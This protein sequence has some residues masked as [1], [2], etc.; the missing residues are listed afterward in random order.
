MKER[1][2][3]NYMVDIRDLVTEHYDQP[4][5]AR[6][7]SGGWDVTANH[8]VSV[9]F[10]PH[11]PTTPWPPP[12]DIDLDHAA[13]ADDAARVIVATH[14]L[15][16]APTD[17][18]ERLEELVGTAN[19]VIDRQSIFWVSRSRYAALDSELRSLHGRPSP[20]PFSGLRLE[21]LPPG[22]LRQFLKFELRRAAALDESHRRLLCLPPAAS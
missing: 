2:D 8:C 10:I 3:S 6:W 14:T 22:E 4:E 11:L 5:L 21:D 15:I 18:Q 7:L 13:D 20:A 16:V 19:D 9:A 17:G 12:Q 1:P